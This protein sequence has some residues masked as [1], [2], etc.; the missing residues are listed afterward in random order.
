MYV[1]RKIDLIKKVSKQWDHQYKRTDQKD[2]IEIGNRLRT[3]RPNTEDEV[4]KIIGNRGWTKNVCDECNNDCDITIQLGQE[5][6]YESATA[7]ICKECLKKAL[8]LT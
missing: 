4:A 7:S 2:K 5:P 3:E 1:V 6:D 8:A